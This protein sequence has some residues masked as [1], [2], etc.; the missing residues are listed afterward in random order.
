MAL[1][2]YAGA[3]RGT[4]RGRVHIAGK[5]RIALTDRKDGKRTGAR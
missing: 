4:K 2:A 5:V 1:A 3:L